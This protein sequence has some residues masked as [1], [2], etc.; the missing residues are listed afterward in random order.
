[1]R[2]ARTPLDLRIASDLDQSREHWVQNP[3]DW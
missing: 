1:L 2:A 3:M